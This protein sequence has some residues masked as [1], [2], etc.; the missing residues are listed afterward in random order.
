MS[1]RRAC[2]SLAVHRSQRPGIGTRPRRPRPSTVGGFHDAGDRSSANRS[3][4]NRQSER[5]M[6]ACRLRPGAACVSAGSARYAWNPAAMTS[7]TTYR[8]PVRPHRLRHRPT[9]RRAA[10]WPPGVFGG[11]RVEPVDVAGD[12]AASGRENRR[13]WHRG[14]CGSWPPN[15]STTPARRASNATGRAGDPDRQCRAHGGYRVRPSHGRIPHQR[16][17]SSSSPR[18]DDPARG[19][20]QPHQG[21]GQH[22]RQ[23]AESTSTAESPQH[24][25]V[26]Y[27]ARTDG[28]SGRVAARRP[29]CRRGGR[30]R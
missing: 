26:I 24:R 29:T 25:P 12:L 6:L 10:T 3:R 4:S 14:R 1:C 20:E 5:A 8:Q 18:P 27:R 22:G 23:G 2:G 30:R 28:S 15:T 9:V 7:S 21:A 17:C 16:L 19:A 11:R 13:A